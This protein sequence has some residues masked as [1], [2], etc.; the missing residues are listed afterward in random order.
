MPAERPS[1]E[2]GAQI[3]HYRVLEKLG[4]GGMGEIYLAKDT[5]LERN[6]ALKVLSRESAADPEGL[7]RFE[8]EAKTLAALNHP[9]I[10]T[11]YSVEE[12]NGIVLY[13][14]ATGVAPSVG[15][16]PPIS[17]RPSCG[18]PRLR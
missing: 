5:H 17:S 3:A 8:R 14:M 7:S 4:E 9:N 6:V 1:L 12:A 18:I 10:V 2:I 15:T 11:I 16:A 13:E